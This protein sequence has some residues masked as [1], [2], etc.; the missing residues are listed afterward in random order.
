MQRGQCKGSRDFSCATEIRAGA[1][2]AGYVTSSLWVIAESFVEIPVALDFIQA[3][4]MCP[5]ITE[6]A[7]KGEKGK[8]C[9]LKWL[10]ALLVAIQGSYHSLNLPSPPAKSQPPGT[11]QAEL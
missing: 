8:A 1:D 11:P 4:A 9:C 10:R 3:H 6:H 2:P 7:L 5:G